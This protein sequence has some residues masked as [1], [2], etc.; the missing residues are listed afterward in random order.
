MKKNFIINLFGVCTRLRSCNIPAP[1]FQKFEELRI[2]N[3]MEIHDFYLNHDVLAYFGYSCWTEL[4][5]AQERILFPL[6]LKNKIEIK[7]ANKKRFQ[8]SANELISPTLF[9]L[10]QLEEK[11]NLLKAR[12]EHQT[13][14]FAQHEI[15]L[16]AKLEL[17]VECFN[18]DLLSFI[19]DAKN[20][21]SE[22]KSLI[23][24]KYDNKLLKVKK[25][26]TVVTSISVRLR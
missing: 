2:K 1:E 3:E 4:P 5:H 7:Q 24:I 12:S 26:D 14:I 23:G 11:S 6:I 22:R 17:N 20:E 18:I 21:L 13:L 25:D 9:P 16:V 8:I 15:G 10:Y 19:L